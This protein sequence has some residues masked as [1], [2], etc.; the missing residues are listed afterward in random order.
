MKISII[1]ATLNNAS[2]IRATID[3]VMAQN[4]ED[5]EYIIV[6]GQSSDGSV[7]II[8]SAIN[9]YGNER[10]KLISIPANGVYN[11]INEGIKVATGDII[12]LMHGNDRYAEC[13]ILTLVALAMK[14]EPEC[15]VVFGDVFYV[16]KN[17]GKIV[18]N[19]RANGF[20]LE[21]L[22]SL[23]APPHPSLFVRKEVYEVY[24]LYKE[25]YI[26]A[27]DFEYIVRILGRERLKYKYLPVDMVAMTD[28]GMSTTLYNRLFTN[29]KEKFRGLVENGLKLSLSGVIK[30]YLSLLLRKR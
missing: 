30:R 29:P 4:Y 19:Y 3:S 15:S 23:F 25:D 10:I 16:D 17:I 20:T 8:K 9:E 1:T 13:D 24:G 7:D 6:D 21:R 11:A 14:N 22:R 28:G 2:Y 5:V 12:G 26:T 27:A 18:R